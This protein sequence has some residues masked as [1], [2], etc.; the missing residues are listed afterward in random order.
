MRHIKI[1]KKNVHLRFEFLKIKTKQ[2]KYK[3]L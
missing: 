2:F 1:V 3:Q